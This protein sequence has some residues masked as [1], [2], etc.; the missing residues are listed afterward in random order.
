MT[1]VSRVQQQY[2]KV[3]TQRLNLAETVLSPAS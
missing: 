2:E 3:E 1:V